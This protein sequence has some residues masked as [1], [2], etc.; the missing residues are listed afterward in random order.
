[1]ALLEDQPIRESVPFSAVVQSSK[2]EFGISVCARYRIG[3]NIKLKTST[4]SLILSLFEL[5]QLYNFQSNN[6]FRIYFT[7][8]SIYNTN[9]VQL[10]T[11]D[12]EALL[13]FRPCF[14]Y[15]FYLH[16][17]PSNSILI[18]NGLVA[19]TVSSG[20]NPLSRISIADTIA[21]AMSFGP[22][23]F[24]ASSLSSLFDVKK[25]VVTSLGFTSDTRMLKGLNSACHDWVIP[26]T[27]NFDA[28]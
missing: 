17:S 6:L 23:L 20:T 15:L 5:L 3:I 8:Q 26:R 11:S 2:F 7:Q 28:A 19:Q 13:G 16:V 27:A 9:L 14:Y 10:F 12:G 22:S 21:W 1:M 25:A 24:G 18:Q 4:N